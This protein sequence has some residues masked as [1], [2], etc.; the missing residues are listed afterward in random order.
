DQVAFAGLE[1]AD[2]LRQALL[3]GVASG[4]VTVGSNPFGV[5]AAQIFVNLLLKLAVRMNFIRHGNFLNEGSSQKAI[6]F[7]TL[8]YRW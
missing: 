6:R 4:A 7:H 5:L 8:S 3:V 2:Q 1:T